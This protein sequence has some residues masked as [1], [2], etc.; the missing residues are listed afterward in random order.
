MRIKKVQVKNF[1]LL[2]N[3]E[4][5]LDEHMTL[6]VGRNNSGKTSLAEL[7]RRL[8]SEKAAGFS[9]EDF[10]LAAHS[11]FWDALQMVRQKRK[12]TDVRTALPSIE[13]TLTVGYDKA[14]ASFGPLSDFIVDLDPDCEEA[15]VD[16]CYQLGDGKLK[17]FLGEIEVD[18]EAD[19]ALQKAILLQKMK[20]LVPKH[21]SCKVFARDP[22]DPTNE[23]PLEWA[24]L[25][26]LI[27]GDLVSAQRGIDDITHKENDSL[28]RILSALF[29][30]A[31]QENSREADQQTVNTLKEG[32][33]NV[34]ESIDKSFN[35][36]LTNLLPALNLFG[37]RFPDPN[38]QTETSLD[39]GLL[40]RNHTK[41][42]YAG[43]NGISLPEAYNGLGTRNLIYILLK[44]FEAFKSFK[45][46]GSEPG[47]HLMFIEEPEAHL[48]PQ[49]QEVFVSKLEVIA[50]LFA[51]RYGDGQP[52]PVQFVVTTHS[53]HMANKAE[54][55]SIRYFLAMPDSDV[56]GSSRTK[57]KDL[58]LNF[59]DRENKD[60][61]FLHQYMT[62]TR[63]DLLFADKVILIEGTSER[64]LL[65]VMIGK[66]DAVLADAEKLESQY[67]SVLE[68]G[69][70]YS[71]IFFRLLD[72][73]EL[74]AL[75]ITDLDSVDA[76]SEACV[77]SK[78]AGTSNAS[79][80]A[81]F[82]VGAISPQELLEKIEADKI[83]G[84]RR[85]AYQ[86]PEPGGPAC[87]RSLEGAFMLANAAK[88]SLNAA[89]LEKSAW[90]KAAKAKKSEFALKHAIRDTDWA[91]PHYIR[92]GLIWLAKTTTEASGSKAGQAAVQAV[93]AGSHGN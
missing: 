28:S 65:P 84:V 88:F 24:K 11:G 21:Y 29:E 64:L 47:M 1:R 52:W 59:G 87:G 51:D 14:A 79:I 77:V 54:F 63:C 37:Y 45:A 90:D 18:N 42:R 13:V 55:N 27:Q 19:E 35:G 62:L 7:F 76:A 46:R 25:R 41:I 92:E 57:V 82:D 60:N 68:V 2:K 20:E 69:G 10:S 66:V 50:K 58:K 32:V 40:L 49:M 86:V 38:I 34:Q 91:V 72:F 85:I 73:L 83:K 74:P 9:L 43:A 75:I 80:K 53:S 15:C 12:D 33:K 22:N 56:A 3:T 8:L 89:D 67:I 31:G 39:V 78:G 93:E 5:C 36:Q 26:E 48:H 30:S 71:H 17:V 70:A 44:L 6:I 16:I 23:R 61:E 81:W 4:L